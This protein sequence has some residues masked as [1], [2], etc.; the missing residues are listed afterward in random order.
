MRKA[1]LTET[2]MKEE[3]KKEKLTSEMEEEAPSN[4][5]S[6]DLNLRRKENFGNELQQRKPSWIRPISG[7][8]ERWV[9][10]KLPFAVEQTTGR[11]TF[12]PQSL[13]G[14]EKKAKM[15]DSN[16]FFFSSLQSS[17]FSLFESEIITISF[18]ERFVRAHSLFLPSDGAKTPSR[19]GILLC[20]YLCPDKIDS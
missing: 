14:F 3:Q 10:T 6:R 11:R 15:A 20:M 7:Q 18:E 17:C 19:D 5:S 1:K 2:Q 16:P 13:L 8:I 9:S 4:G 12:N